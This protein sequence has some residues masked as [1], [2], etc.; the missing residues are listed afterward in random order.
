M[1]RRTCVSKRTP[2]KLL[3]F[4]VWCR[5]LGIW[6]VTTQL[7]GQLQI[8]VSTSITKSLL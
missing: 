6:W 4:P 2:V 5:Q 3:N 1:V 8:C 7:V